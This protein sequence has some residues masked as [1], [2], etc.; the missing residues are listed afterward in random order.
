MNLISLFRAEGSL[1]PARIA[2]MSA[3]AGLSSAG[4][5]VVINAAADNVEHHRPTTF[6][7]FLFLGVVAI[8]VV[9]KRF[10]MLTA[11]RETEQI[12]HS[13]RMRIMSK[14]IRSDLLA[15][16][17]VGRSNILAAAGKETQTISQAS[18]FLTNA[19]ESLTM[20]V[21][22][23]IYLAWLSI[24]AFLIGLGFTC[25]AVLIHFRQLRSVNHEL[26]DAIA[27]ENICL[28]AMGDI[29][30]GFKEAKINSKRGDEIFDYFSQ[31]SAAA[32]N[33][34]MTAQARMAGHFTLTQ[35]MFYLLVATMVFVAPI[36]SES[37]SE[38]VVKTA[39]AVLFMFGAIS[40]LVGSIPILTQANAAAGAVRALEDTLDRASPPS[41]KQR[42]GVFGL[43]HELRFRDVTF[44]HHDQKT[45]PGFA[46][47]P[48]N[49]TLRA[50]EMVFVTGG[51]GSGKS[52]LMKLL[53]GLYRPLSGRIEVDGQAV[54][55]EDV[56]AYR[57][58]FATVFSDFH[59]FKR[60]F[61]LFD[62]DQEKIDALLN[63]LEIQ[64]KTAV[65]DGEFSTLDL[66]GGQR[67]RIALLVALLENRQIIVLDEWAADQDPYFRRKFY[68]ELLPE[69]RRQGKTIICITHDDSYFHLADRQLK[70]EYGQ[71]ATDTGGKADA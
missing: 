60:L 51:N 71:L 28:D 26:R 55:D 68:E 46:V 21:F 32:A 33:K 34:K 63:L 56:E 62:A 1:Q 2:V 57:N 59:L 44:S 47:G 25:L 23:V 42:Q 70:L 20:L 12:V 69:L 50:G 48:I 53:V 11:I 3:L 15:I 41:R 7:F 54:T 67:K 19:A 38:V 14:V 31:Q 65:A 39:T 37:F 24:S 4:V 45:Q 36:F 18:F 49:L 13:I 43:F 64:N 27:Q 29:L 52:T 61:G 35:T 5:L 9:S 16:D 6:F 58:L 10:I 66:S 22:S 40:T 8:Y 17:Q 30:S